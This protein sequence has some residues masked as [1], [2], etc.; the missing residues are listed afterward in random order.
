MN[1]L[2]VV[3]HADPGMMAMNELWPPSVRHRRPLGEAWKCGGGPTVPGRA[4]VSGDHLGLALLC[5]VVSLSRARLGLSPWR[6]C[7]SLT[8]RPVHGV[9]PASIEGAAQAW[10]RTTD[11]QNSELGAPGLSCQHDPP[12]GPH[13]GVCVCGGTTW[14]PRPVQHPSPAFPRIAPG[15]GSHVHSFG[16]RV[17]IGRCPTLGRPLFQGLERQC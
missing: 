10:E 13:V 3:R 7:L 4:W 6:S 5:Q 16:Q 14:H 12:L 17:A 15:T 2:P 1:P 11:P 9:C 8:Q